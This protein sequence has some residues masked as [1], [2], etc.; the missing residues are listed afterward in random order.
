MADKDAKKDTE[1]SGGWKNFIYNPETGQF[2]GRTA[3]SWGKKRGA[4]DG[5]EGM[6][7]TSAQRAHKNKSLYSERKKA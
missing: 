2:M 1:Q 6:A 5:R 3:S 7:M 4:R